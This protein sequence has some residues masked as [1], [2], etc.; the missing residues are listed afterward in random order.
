MRRTSAPTHTCPRPV[1]LTYHAYANRRYTRSSPSA[2]T[3]G[4]YRASGQLPLNQISWGILFARIFGLARCVS[5][6]T[7]D[8]FDG[9]T[10]ELPA[11][12]PFIC[13]S[14]LILKHNWAVCE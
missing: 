5:S 8:V 13:R 7:R 14:H 1:C 11:G 2:S 10:D 3:T 12:N 4:T 6:F 9:P